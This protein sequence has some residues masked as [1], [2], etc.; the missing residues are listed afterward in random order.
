VP[1]YVRIRKFMV[2]TP[3]QTLIRRSNQERGENGG[4]CSIH[5]GEGKYIYIILVK[6]LKEDL[7]VYG[8]ITLKWINLA[9]RTDKWLATVNILN[10]RVYIM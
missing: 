5:W 9:Q 6:K 1:L 2:R 8:R 4:A 10:L 3:L 7:E